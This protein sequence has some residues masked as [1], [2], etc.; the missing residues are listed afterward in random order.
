M[1]L[2]GLVDSSSAAPLRGQ[3][4]FLVSDGQDLSTTEL[5]RGMA[6]APGVSARLLAVPMLTL[7]WVLK[8]DFH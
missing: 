8:T 1:A 5:V 2:V 3:P 7:P 4:D 6:Q